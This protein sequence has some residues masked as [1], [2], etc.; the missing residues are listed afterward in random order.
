MRG[1]LLPKNAAPESSGQFGFQEGF[2]RIDKSVFKVHQARGA[3]GKPVQRAGADA[4]P[5][6]AKVWSVTRLDEELNPLVDEVTE[7]QLK[8]ELI[9]A[10]GGKS[11]VSVHPGNVSGPDDEEAE[12][13]GDTPGAEGNSLYFVNADFKVHPKASVMVLMESILK[14]RPDLEGILERQYAPDDVGCV[15]HMK[16]WIDEELKQEYTDKNGKKVSKGTP[17]KIVDKVIIGPGEKKK[18]SAAAGAGTNAASNGHDPAVDKKLRE[19]IAVLAGKHDG[20]SC[21][22]KALSNRVNAWMQAAK[23]APKLLAPATALCRDV[24]WLSAN[25]ADMGI[26]VDADTGMVEFGEQTAAE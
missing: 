3:D 16:S 15:F 20:S 14:Q 17:Y 24:A 13:L 18:K 25:A 12:D 9:F 21:T 19:A 6:C 22:V 2:V 4:V 11:L 1:A 5:V 10:L 7:E 23:V 8:E 26:A